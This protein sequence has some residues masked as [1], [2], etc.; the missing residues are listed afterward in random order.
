MDHPEIMSPLSKWHRSI[1]GLT[2]RFELFACQK[3]IV[4]AYTE[5]NDPVVQR[6]RFAQQTQE[7]AKGDD[8]AQPVDENFCT[9]LEYGLP[10][11]GGWGLGID[12]LTMFLTDSAN[13]KEVLFFPAMKPDDGSSKSDS[14]AAA[15]VPQPPPCKD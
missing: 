12:R 6:E 1:P 9:A 5:L 7:K 2:E 3:E 13:I 10:P 14:A 4:N 15:A 11:T 8:E